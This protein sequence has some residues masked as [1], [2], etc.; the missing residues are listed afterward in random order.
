MKKEKRKLAVPKMPTVKQRI[1][2][3]DRIDAV[4]RLQN[5]G[6][7]RRA[8]IFHQGLKDEHDRLSGQFHKMGNVS[9][10]RGKIHNLKKLMEEAECRM[11][12][13]GVANLLRRRQLLTNHHATSEYMAG[14]HSAAPTPV[15]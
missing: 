6:E 7:Q 9:D 11:E 1:T 15:T 10:L 5:I 3:A 4:R 2:M 14:M 13:Q 8:Q 12:Q